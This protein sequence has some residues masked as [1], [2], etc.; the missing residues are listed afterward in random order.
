MLAR[1]GAVAMIL[2]P[3]VARGEFLGHAQRERGLGPDRLEPRRDLLDRLSGVV[4]Q[5]ASALQ[6]GRLLDSVT[7]QARHDGL[8][9]LANRSLFTERME[10]ALAGRARERRAGRP[11]SSSTS[12][13]SRRV[14]DQWG[15]HVGDELLCQVAARLLDT[16]RTGDTVARLGGDE[17]AIVLVR[18][19]RRQG[20][21]EAAAERVALAFE[22]AVRASPALSSPS[23]ASVGARDLARGRVE[24]EALM[25]HAD[26]E[27]YRAKRVRSGA[28]E[29]P[30]LTAV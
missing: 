13:A 24:I 18:R 2:A 17:F 27:M 25:R 1:L 29:Q 15:H 7:H 10:Q 30:R 9:G 16:V 12:T 4:A 23:A 11:A 19:Q 22:R 6:T 3:I 14:N 5:A 26:A 21:L 8:T 20:E 28:R